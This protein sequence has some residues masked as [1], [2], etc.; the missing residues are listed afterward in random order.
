MNGKIKKIIYGVMSVIT[1]LIFIAAMPVMSLLTGEKEWVE[2]TTR[3]NFVLVG[4]ASLAIVSLVAYIF[5][6][7]KFAASFAKEKNK[8]MLPYK[9]VKTIYVALEVMEAIIIPVILFFI[10]M[11]LGNVASKSIQSAALIVMIVSASLLGIS[12]IWGSVAMHFYKKNFDAKK[13]EEAQQYIF[14]HREHAEK[15]ADEKLKVLKRTI[16]AVNL[17][18]TFLVILCVASSLT[19]GIVITNAVWSVA[20]LVL[21]VLTM[22][23]VFLRFRAPES[24]SAFEDESYVKEED[25]PRI[26]AL[27]Q[28]AAD[29]HSVD[30]DIKICVGG[31]FNASIVRIGKVNSVQLGAI[32]VST[33]SED[34]LY[35]VFLHEFAHLVF[36]KNARQE[37][38]YFAWI[39]ENQ[40]RGMMNLPFRFFD[41]F[42]ILQYFFYNY[43]GSLISEE[44]ADRS[45]REL[46]D[47]RSAASALL[48]MHY[49]TMFAW[50]RGT[51]DDKAYYSLESE[52]LTEDY[53]LHEIECYRQRTELRHEFWNKLIDGEILARNASHPTL[54]M[55]LETL[56]Q[57]D[58]TVIDTKHSEEYGAET[59]KFRER[60]EKL[61][62]DGRKDNYE[63]E[64][65]LGFVEP[66]KLIEKWEGDGK[67][68]VPE[69][70]GDVIIA[71][72][73]LGRVEDAYA[74][75]ERAI[76]ELPVSASVFA[77]YIK[78]CML[79][80]RFDERGIEC[81]YHAIEKNPNYIDEG[82]ET[83]GQYCCIAGRE[84]D[85]EEYRKNA[86][87]LMKATT[88][89]YGAMEYIL[90]TDKI[91]AEE[92]PS[93][94][95]EGLLDYVR[96][97]DN[98][99]IDEIYLIR[100]TIT[101][102]FFCSP[103]IV[104][105]KKDASDKDADEVM[106]KI[107]SHLDT[108]SDWQFAQFDSRSLPPIVFN[109][110]KCIKGALIYKS[111][112]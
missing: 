79:L 45:M 110:I 39:M 65:N 5:F 3:D 85:L 62:Y 111:E 105:L 69:E 51:Y 29:A 102:D 47:A 68:L 22:I 2:F 67:P 60:V 49:Y 37:K 77:Y 43:A 53:M 20:I 100:K 75:C 87:E 11:A 88:E 50:E 19:A 72:R 16:N 58:Y 112:K 52:T 57:T 74:L 31:D 91:S 55:R 24:K 28:K 64:R 4:F 15:T 17:Y 21:C 42:Y 101:D 96:Q 30:G 33:L 59:D 10:G 93:E 23:S 92:L 26:Y 41:T 56:G 106:H 89:K 36:D 99:A 12:Y 8:G 25:F 34:E 82:I 1:L 38:R 94:L 54:K 35:T 108:A 103:V 97:V 46:G 44:R 6:L 107:F 48:K 18:S 80:H 63:E 7:F 98:G 109:K 86:L 70:Y 66:A 61:I 14:S 73:N 90:P 84:D 40:D 78:G 76:E 27:A 71:M 81:I 95:Y 13:P 9:S 32:L 104:K 83:I